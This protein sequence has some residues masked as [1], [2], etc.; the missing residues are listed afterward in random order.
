MV[1]STQNT[2]AHSI[3]VLWNRPNISFMM[4]SINV[5]V[6]RN[7]GLRLHFFAPPPSVRINNLKWRHLACVFSVSVT[8]SILIFYVLMW[9]CHANWIRSIFLVTVTILLGFSG[10]GALNTGF[11]IISPCLVRASF[12]LLERGTSWAKDTWRDG[13]C[14]FC[15]SKDSYHARQHGPTGNNMEIVYSR[16]FR[17]LIQEL[18][19]VPSTP[20]LEHM[21]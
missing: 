18:Q 21:A 7:P 6:F 17:Q 8:T 5:R 20:S 13:V 2:L 12:T 9:R 15:Y 11:Y 16:R 19:L 14:V 4:A 3:Y 1:S 10:Y